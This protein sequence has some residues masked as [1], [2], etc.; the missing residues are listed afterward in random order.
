VAVLAEARAAVIGW[1]DLDF[2]SSLVEWRVSRRRD[3]RFALHLKRGHDQLALQLSRGSLER[4]WL[5]LSFGLTTLATP[6]QPPLPG[7]LN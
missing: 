2:D 4:L 3:G 5:L 7:S 6:G 1:I